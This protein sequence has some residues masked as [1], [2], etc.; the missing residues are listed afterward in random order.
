MFNPFNKTVKEFPEN[1]STMKVKPS[2][3]PLCQ[4]TIGITND[5]RTVLSI[6][7]NYY[8]TAKMSMNKDEVR[9][10]IRLLEAT[11]SELKSD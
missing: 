11:I 10:L 1:L 2:E 7:E 8:C 9:Q 3:N 6:A 4:Y 5:G